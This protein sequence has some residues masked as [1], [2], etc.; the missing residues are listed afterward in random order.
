MAC[1]TGLVIDLWTREDFLDRLGDRDLPGVGNLVAVHRDPP[2]WRDIVIDFR[3][4]R[5]ILKNVD[6]LG[7]AGNIV[8]QQEKA[9]AE[10]DQ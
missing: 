8:H 3:L 2:D 4:V 10:P 5:G 9:E 6:F 1:Q 7:L